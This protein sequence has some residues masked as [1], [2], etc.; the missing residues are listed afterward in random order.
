MSH[1]FNSVKRILT[2]RNSPAIVLSV[3]ALVAGLAG[4]AVAQNAHTSKAVTPAK[5]KKIAKK[6]VV[7]ANYV[8]TIDF[9]NL[10]VNT[11]ETQFIAP[12]VALATTD[13][14]ITTPGST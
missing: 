4:G 5:V 8:L 14:I 11:C 10:A 7:K 2:S 6:A 3:I 12:P 13:A 1:L 9:A